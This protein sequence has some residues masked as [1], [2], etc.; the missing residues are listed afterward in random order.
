MDEA[1]QNH[2]GWKDCTA[3]GAEL[4]VL[5]QGLTTSLRDKV[6]WLEESE[7]FSLQFP[8]NRRRAVAEGRLE[9]SQRR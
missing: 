9:G 1:L 3:E 5:R 8:A 2:P 6:R 7:A 4:A